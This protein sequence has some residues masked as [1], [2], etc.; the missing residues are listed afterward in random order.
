MY[1][2]GCYVN[3]DDISSERD[4]LRE[5]KDTICFH[6]IIKAKCLTEQKLYIAV[7]IYHQCP[8]LDIDLIRPERWTNAQAVIVCIQGPPLSIP[9]D[10]PGLAIFIETMLPRF[11]VHFHF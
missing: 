6:N 1:R 3:I 7:N 11:L 9:F 4:L 2:G 5:R 10:H 8:T